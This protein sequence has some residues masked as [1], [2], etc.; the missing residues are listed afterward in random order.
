M[1]DNYQILCK[2]GQGSFGSVFKV[3][4]LKSNEIFALKV[5]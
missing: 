2:I 4:S 3:I 5:L 1:K